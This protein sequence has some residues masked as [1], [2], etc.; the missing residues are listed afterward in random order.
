MTTQLSSMFPTSSLLTPEGIRERLESDLA[1]ERR[2][3][4][5]VAV[6]LADAPEGVDLE[7]HAQTADARRQRIEELEAALGRLEAGQYG[8]CERCS[9]PVAAERLEYLPHAR[10][11]VACQGAADMG[12]AN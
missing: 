3:Q 7:V 9:R 11:C 1:V 12:V 2:A 10:Y 8:Q 6:V 4:H 5:S